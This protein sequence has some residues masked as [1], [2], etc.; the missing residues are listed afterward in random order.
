MI[1]V[2]YGNAGHVGEGVD[3]LEAKRRRAFETTQEVRA[4]LVAIPDPAVGPVESLDD[5]R[6]AMVGRVGVV[7]KNRVNVMRFQPDTTPPQRSV[8]VRP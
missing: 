8:L 2:Q 7:G 6:R 3:Q 5:Q 1:P 4:E